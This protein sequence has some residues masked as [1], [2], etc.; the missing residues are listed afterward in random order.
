[1]KLGMLYSLEKGAK[2]KLNKN[3][4]LDSYALLAKIN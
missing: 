4:K 1:M 2:F 3:L